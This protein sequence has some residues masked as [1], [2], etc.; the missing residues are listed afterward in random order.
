MMNIC[1]SPKQYLYA[2]TL[3]D[4]CSCVINNSNYDSKA[5]IIISLKQEF[6]CIHGYQTKPYYSEMIMNYNYTSYADLS[7]LVTDAL[8]NYHYL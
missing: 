1:T 3:N 4:V 7:Y 2:I 6:S 8:Y 5:I